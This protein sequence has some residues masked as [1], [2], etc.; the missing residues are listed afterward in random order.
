MSFNWYLHRG[1]NATVR[2]Y[3]ILESERLGP[4]KTNFSEYAGKWDWIQLFPK[5]MGETKRIPS[6]SSQA[7][8]IMGGTACGVANRPPRY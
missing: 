4:C 5:N 1:P 3:L 8:W 6:D 2:D 7:L